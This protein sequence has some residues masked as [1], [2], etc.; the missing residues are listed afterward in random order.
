VSLYGI[1]CYKTD[2]SVYALIVRSAVWGLAKVEGVVG[3]ID[4]RVRDS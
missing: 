4:C 2:R 1:V 3:L